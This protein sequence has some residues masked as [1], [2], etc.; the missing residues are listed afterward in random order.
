M[1]PCHS[2]I[3]QEPA[4]QDPSRRWDTARTTCSPSHSHSAGSLLLV[5]AHVQV[6]SHPEQLSGR[7]RCQFLLEGRERFMPPLPL[8]VCVCHRFCH[9]RSQQQPRPIS[10]V[11][12]GEVR[13]LQRLRCSG[14]PPC[15]W[16]CKQL[17]DFRPHVPRTC[18]G[19]LGGRPQHDLPSLSAYS[20][21]ETA[22]SHLILPLWI[23]EPFSAVPSAQR[24]KSSPLDQ[25]ASCGTAAPALPRLPRLRHRHV[26]L[27]F[28]HLS[29]FGQKEAHLDRGATCRTSAPAPPETPPAAAP[30]AA[31]L[32]PA[33]S[34]AWQSPARRQ[35]PARPRRSGRRTSGPPGPAGRCRSRRA[36]AAPRLCS[37]MR[38]WAR[39]DGMRKRGPVSCLS[40][41]IVPATGQW[42][43]VRRH[44]TVPGRGAV[45]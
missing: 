6:I 25:G 14:S 10:F 7:Q 8:C 38:V 20:T 26:L 31:P 5:T 28:V 4:G 37:G 43:Q 27:T 36:A 12:G 45:D 3:C 23:A 21:A 32:A 30:P 18:R 42:P 40:S 44:A 13:I 24:A 15:T 41:A 39:Q 22:R 16:R 35:C 17:R 34:A 2:Q 9:L 11:F 1:P 29:I 19:G 33:G